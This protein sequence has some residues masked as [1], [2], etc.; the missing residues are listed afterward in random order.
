MKWKSILELD[1]G[2]DDVEVVLKLE[3]ASDSPG[4]LIKHRW[5]DPTPGELDSLGLGRSLTLP[6]RLECRGA[7][8][9]HCN[10]RLSGSSNSPASASQV[11]DFPPAKTTNEKSRS[12]LS[13]WGA[14]QNCTKV[15]EEAAG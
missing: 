14:V 4:A 9:A 13:L 10:L 2:L 3:C 5:R 1:A 8:S 15:Q 11:A 6:P 12:V 7:I